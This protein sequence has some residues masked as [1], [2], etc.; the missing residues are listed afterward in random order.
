[1]HC[2]TYRDANERLRRRSCLI[3]EILM[4]NCVR[5]ASN[6]VGQPV[7]ADTGYEMHL[8][9]AMRYRTV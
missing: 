9:L 1:M 5:A 7:H 8:V 3:T 6:S 4:S 2:T